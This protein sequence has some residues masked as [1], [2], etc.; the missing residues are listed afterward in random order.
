MVSTQDVPQLVFA[1]QSMVH[2]PERHVLPAP[3][4]TPQPPQLFESALVSTQCPMQLVSPW[5]HEVPHCPALHVA[6]A[7]G[8][9]GQWCPHAP[10]F[11]G[12]DP[13]ARH[14]APHCV[15]P[16]LQTALHAP[17]V[18]TACA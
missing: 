4:S 13:S 1:P 6:T 11:S 16:A 14:A 3:Q 17:F 7:L 2:A 10:Q 18:Q 9:A 8:A 15:Y 5:L 12:S